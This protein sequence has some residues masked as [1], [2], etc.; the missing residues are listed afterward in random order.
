MFYFSGGL[1]TIVEDLEGVSGVAFHPTYKTL[2]WISDS[3][4]LTGLGFYTG[5]VEDLQDG[6]NNPRMLRIDPLVRLGMIRPVP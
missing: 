4:T 5:I 1:V 3:G 6:L 2:Y